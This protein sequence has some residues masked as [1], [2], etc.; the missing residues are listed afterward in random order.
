MA[1]FRCGQTTILFTSN[2]ENWLSVCANSEDNED[3]YNLFTCE[4]N[5]RG[6]LKTQ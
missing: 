4:D 2:R 5:L 3:K 1:N 6:E